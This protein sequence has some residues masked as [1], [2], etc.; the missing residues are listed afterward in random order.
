[1]DEIREDNPIYANIAPKELDT[2]LSFEIKVDFLDCTQEIILAYSLMLA[3]YGI[4]ARLGADRLYISAIL[5]LRKHPAAS[6]RSTSGPR[7]MLRV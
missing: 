4:H 5:P 1:M 7:A 3:A 6:T 2:A